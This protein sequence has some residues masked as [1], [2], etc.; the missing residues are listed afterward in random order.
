MILHA[1]WQQIFVKENIAY[2]WLKR[3]KML[4]LAIENLCYRLANEIFLI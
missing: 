2:F 1:G 4:G 3:R